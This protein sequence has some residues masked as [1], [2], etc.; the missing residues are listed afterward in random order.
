MKLQIMSD[1]H[2]EFGGEFSPS[3][4]DTDVVIL[5]GDI[6]IGNKGLD[7]IKKINKPVIYVVGN[8]EYYRHDITEINKQLSNHQQ[9]NYY[10]L[11][12]SS[13][14]FEGVRVL[15]CTLWTDFCLYGEERQD[16]SMNQADWQMND[17]RQIKL[18]GSELRPKDTL[19]L[20]RE[21]VRWL[22]KELQ[23]PFEG[24]TVVVTH[25]SPSEKSVPER[26]KGSGLNPAFAS[27]LE[28]LM[29]KGVDL[30]VHGHTH[31]SF[32]YLVGNTRVVC[33]P[34]GYVGYETNKDFDDN[35]II[36]V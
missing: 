16:E 12:N 20:H 29:R 26:F 8:H 27:N 21:S 28:W 23:K 31:D 22:E 3:F 18:N 9:S 30:Y 15:G 2:L 14:E 36:E 32:D 4:N 35:L 1:L 6:H 34:R 25:H 17:Y 10:F 7:F 33:N 24:H 11:N 5:A 13:V 19:A